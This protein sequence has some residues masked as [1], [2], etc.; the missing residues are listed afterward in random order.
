MI[1]ERILSQ[2]RSAIVKKWFERVID[3]YPQDASRFLQTQ[4]DPFANPVGRNTLNGLE[5]LVESLFKESNRDSLLA[6]LDQIIRMRAVQAFSP[7]EAIAFIFSLKEIVRDYIGQSSADKGFMDDWLSFESKIDRLALMAFD[8][9]TQCREKMY[10]IRVNEVRRTT[11]S[12]LKRA[13]LITET[14][15]THPD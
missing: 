2:H 8:V 4:K 9:Y 13:N 11:L 10:E 3:S 6:F 5:G 14:P 15:E 7:S 1:L 12:A